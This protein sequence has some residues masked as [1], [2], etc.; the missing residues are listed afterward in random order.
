MDPRTV[1][2]EIGLD[3]ANALMNWRGLPVQGERGT[4][5]RRFKA[6]IADLQKAFDS[7]EG[8]D[9]TRRSQVEARITESVGTLRTLS[10]SQDLPRVQREIAEAVSDVLDLETQSLVR[11]KKEVHAICS[12]HGGELPTK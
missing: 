4:N 5:L 1:T 6:F 12:A 3:F 8:P 7:A 11:L 9:T 10:N 2:R